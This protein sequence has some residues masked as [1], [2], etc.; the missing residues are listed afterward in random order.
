MILKKFSYHTDMKS[1]ENKY[2]VNQELLAKIRSPKKSESDIYHLI[3]MVSDSTGVSINSSTCRVLLEN[4]RSWIA[5]PL[6]IR[7]KIVDDIIRFMSSDCLPLQDNVEKMINGH[8]IVVR[9]LAGT[10]PPESEHQR[11]QEINERTRRDSDIEK[12]RTRTMN[13]IKYVA[14]KMKRD[15]GDFSELED[16][17]LPEIKPLP[18]VLIAESW[19]DDFLELE[20]E[21]EE[22]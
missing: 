5:L 13:E 21:D 22:I 11:I 10:M 18:Q 17:T 20:F 7:A 15:S 9:Y 19:N 6:R 16:P 8:P 3:W 14:T 1:S 4:M 12:L 2:P